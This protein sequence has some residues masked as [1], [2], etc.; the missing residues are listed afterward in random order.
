MAK[1]VEDCNEYNHFSKW[2]DNY[3]NSLPYDELCDFCYNHLN[4]DVDMEA[5]DHD[6][7][8]H[9]PKEIIEMAK[10]PDID[11]K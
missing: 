7:E 4:A 8:V 10:E 11:K 3:I 2:L 9:I 6:Y 5:S 1:Y